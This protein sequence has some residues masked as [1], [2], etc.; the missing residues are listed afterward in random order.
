MS[1]GEAP[2]LHPRI[3]YASSPASE[4]S[5]LERISVNPV[6]RIEKVRRVFSKSA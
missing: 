3:V 5:T 1:E 2:V 6:S 4:M